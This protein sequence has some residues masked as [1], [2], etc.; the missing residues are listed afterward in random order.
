MELL[1]QSSRAA[2][3][4]D[5]AQN[6][7]LSFADLKAWFLPVQGTAWA[8]L[9]SLSLATLCLAPLARGRAAWPA[10][11]LCALGLLL[12]FGF[13]NPALNRHPTLALVWLSLGL[14]LLTGLG[15]QRLERPALL[16]LAG[17][18]LLAQPLLF[19]SLK[20]QLISDSV[21]EP[22]PAAGILA[23]KI[24]PQRRFLLSPAVQ[25]ERNTSGASLTAAWSNFP[26]W[27]QA[28]T[29]SQLGL[30]DANG[31][32]PLAPAAIVAK[33]NA[34]SFPKFAVDQGLLDELGVEAVGGLG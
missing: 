13:F 11:L 1:S 27:M 34:V 7:Q 26:E 9:F 30:K 5:A 32:D 33:L 21:Y 2:G 17:L 29:S 18:C 31:Y 15:A 3:L 23:E 22:K 10:L 8:K 28:N 12:S 4:A 14:S 6:Y 20:L 24:T 16:F 19:S 25:E